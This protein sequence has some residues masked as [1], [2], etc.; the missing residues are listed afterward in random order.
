MKT[1]SN[2]INEKLKINKD[3]K[4]ESKYIIFF[5]I[6][7]ADF[8][9]IYELFDNINDASEYI[10]SEQNDDWAFSFLIQDTKELTITNLTSLITDYSRARISRESYLKICGLKK[11]E[12]VDD[13]L[14]KILNIKDD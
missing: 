4:D 13:E 14:K 2:Y 12:P 9:F 10:H 7:G 11:Y 6:N 3:S 8:D 1:F 5:N